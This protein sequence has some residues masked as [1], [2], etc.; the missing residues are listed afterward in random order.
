MSNAPPGE[1]VTDTK[2]AALV[3]LSV[4]PKIVPV[5]RF[6]P[7][8]KLKVKSSVDAVTPDEEATARIAAATSVLSVKVKIHIYFFRPI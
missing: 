3:L 8:S 5:S 6:A 7:S 2:D 4:N 1:L